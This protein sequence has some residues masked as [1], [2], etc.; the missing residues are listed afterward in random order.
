M[1]NKSWLMLLCSAFMSM[2][3][4]SQEIPFVYEVENTEPDV[5]PI[6]PGFNELPAVKPLPDPFLWSDGSGY[7]TDFKDWSRRR[8]EI[9][10]EIEH[11]EIGEKPT[12]DRRCIRA[13]MADDTL[14]VH[15]TVGGR[16]LRLSAGIT[17]PEGEGPFPALQFLHKPCQD[18]QQILFLKTHP[19]GPPPCGREVHAAL[20]V[21]NTDRRPLV[22]RLHE[23]EFQQDALAAPCGAA[24]QDMG[25]MGQIDRHRPQQALSQHQYKTLRG[26]VF[27]LPRED[28]RQSGPCRGGIEQDAALALAVPHF[29]NIQ[30][31]GGLYIRPLVLP[32]VQRD[33]PVVKLPNGDIGIIPVPPLAEQGG[34]H[35]RM[36]DKANA[37]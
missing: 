6:L 36:I 1:G 25:D 11:Y 22:D 10:R 29:C 32:L 3:I 31:Q 9:G 19:A 18:I 15:V 35:P 8:A 17:Y 2:E 33:P 13:E 5:S 23:Q 24:Q 4:G 30:I 16:T 34:G 7:C 12:V 20:E 26:Q 21:R 14:F 37:L 28:V 27:V